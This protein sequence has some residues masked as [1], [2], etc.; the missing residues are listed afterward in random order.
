MFDPHEIGERRE[1]FKKNE[2]NECFFEQ[3]NLYLESFKAKKI[4][5]AVNDIS[6]LPI[7][8]IVGVPRSG[9]TLLSQLIC[10]YLNV[11]Y[12]DNIA[13]KFWMNPVVGMN[14][15]ESLKNKEE[16]KLTLNSIHGVTRDVFGPHEFG[17][18]WRHWFLLD[19][20]MSHK[21]SSVELNRLD[22][23]GFRKRLYEILAVKNLPMVFKNVICGFQAE[24]LTS[25]HQNSIFLYMKRDIGEVC[26]S[27]LKARYDRY[28][29]YSNW[30]SL[31]PPTVDEILRI[32][33]P[34]EQVVR[35][36]T[37]CSIEFEKELI[38]PY[39]NFLEI[40]Y[41][42]LCNSPSVVLNR[43]IGEISMMYGS[44]EPVN[45]IEALVPSKGHVLPSDMKESISKI[46]SYE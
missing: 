2:E 36:V 17:Y 21:L 10:K 35:Q 25:A 40:E 13:A 30:W 5:S 27:I 23:N 6:Q 11:S 31:M 26:S 12:I 4:E 7:I 38:K 24:W 34:V 14:L 28:G 15:S 44:F 16:N 22:I 42:E 1:E 32:N 3:L 9:T 41:N 8:Y 18:F 39:I 33:D 46:L 29:D 20:A 19:D 37:D 45:N 43:I